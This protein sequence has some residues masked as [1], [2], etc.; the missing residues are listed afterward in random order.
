MV[1]LNKSSQGEGVR[2]GV[3]ND[4][5][6]KFIININ[7]QNFVYS[8]AFLFFFSCLKNYASIR[9]HFYFSFLK[10]FQTFVSFIYNF[11]VNETALG[12]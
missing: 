12:M 10:N 7:N 4:I 2:G 3:I 1:L 5:V 11:R 8:D 6:F 9:L